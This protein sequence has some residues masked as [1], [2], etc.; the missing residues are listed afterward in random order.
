MLRERERNPCFIY[1]VSFATD[2]ARKPLISAPRH[3]KPAPSL[4]TLQPR[5]DSSSLQQPTSTNL[6]LAPRRYGRQRIERNPHH[7]LGNLFYLASSWACATSAALHRH[8]SKLLCAN[9]R[10]ITATFS[11]TCITVSKL[12]SN[13]LI[14]FKLYLPSPCSRLSSHSSSSS[15]S[16]LAIANGISSASSS[17][18][19]LSPLAASLFAAPAYESLH[20]SHTRQPKTSILPN[21]LAAL[22]SWHS[23]A[24]SRLRSSDP[25]I[26]QPGC[27]VALVGESQQQGIPPI[28]ANVTRF[29]SRFPCFCR[30]SAAACFRTRLRQRYPPSAQSHARFQVF[31]ATEWRATK[32]IRSA[33][34]AFDP[35][36][37]QS[38]IHRVGILWYC[39]TRYIWLCCCFCSFFPSFS[40]R[41][42][43]FYSCLFQRL[44][45]TRRA[46]RSRY[47]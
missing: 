18:S 32:P 41:T 34:I 25:P 5:H 38:S 10:L 29:N 28:A 30:L 33:A 46:Q 8:S 35:N 26:S 4:I 20:P 23:F 11:V 31:C 27:T 43:R 14:S 15:T 40:Q 17:I 22:T 1:A 12:C 3:G 21:P 7:S 39:I 9:H 42:D 44:L 2:T 6:S 16:H 45:S 13:K 47:A 36:A 19:I 37:R 24:P